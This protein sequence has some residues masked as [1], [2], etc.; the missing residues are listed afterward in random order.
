MKL[1]VNEHEGGKSDKAEGEKG[2][3]ESV[4]RYKCIVRE[5]GFGLQKR[6][7]GGTRLVQ[8]KKKMNQEE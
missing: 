2:A 4:R 3:N 6:V 7:E 8:S 5:K 1:G